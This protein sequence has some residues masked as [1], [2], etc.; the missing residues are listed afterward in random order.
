MFYAVYCHLLNDGGLNPGR[1]L[2]VL[3][4][5]LFYRV[6]LVFYVSLLVFG[7]G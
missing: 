7:G 5:S 4:Q 2:F 3:G 6:A 1:S